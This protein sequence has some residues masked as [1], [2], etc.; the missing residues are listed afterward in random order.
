MRRGRESGFK[1]S[2]ENVGPKT[3]SS[4]PLV[5]G[6]TPAHQ[7]GDASGQEQGI[8]P[9]YFPSFLWP[10]SLFLFSVFFLF[11]LFLEMLW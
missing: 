6:R 2:K 8:Q 11:L 1:N 4:F 3:I 9:S 7:E 5:L 10:F